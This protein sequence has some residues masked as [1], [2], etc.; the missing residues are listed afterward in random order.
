VDIAIGN[1][2]NK[3]VIVFI[4]PDVMKEFLSLKT[5]LKYKKLEYL[6]RGIKGVFGDGLLFSSGGTRKSKR[7]IISKA[8]KFELLKENIPRYHASVKD[9][10]TSLTKKRKL[11]K[12]R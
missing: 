3:A 2:I 4:K 7:K 6:V 9:G 10:S 11:H 1:T 8:F 5:V 12:T